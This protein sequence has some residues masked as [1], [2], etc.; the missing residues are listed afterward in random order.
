MAVMIALVAFVIACIGC[1]VGMSLAEQL[2]SARSRRQARAQYELNSAWQELCAEQE[3]MGLWR[4]EQGRYRPRGMVVFDPFRLT[5]TKMG[6]RRS[7]K[8][9]GSTQWASQLDMVSGQLKNVSVSR[10]RPR[11]LNSA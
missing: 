7:T 8:A 1:L 10:T 9:M 2:M 4:A 11:Q 3:A 6:K 5:S